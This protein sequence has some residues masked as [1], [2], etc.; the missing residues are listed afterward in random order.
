MRL[1]ILLAGLLVA[2]APAAAVPPG[3]AA[4]AT[5]SAAAPDPFAGLRFLLGEWTAGRGGGELRTHLQGMA[6]RT[7]G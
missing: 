1:S 4:G 3:P 2:P 7:R 6:S 5:P